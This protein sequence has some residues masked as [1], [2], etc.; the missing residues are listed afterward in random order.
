[1]RKKPANGMEN[2]K[3]AWFQSCGIVTIMPNMY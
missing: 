2:I 1:M 3:R